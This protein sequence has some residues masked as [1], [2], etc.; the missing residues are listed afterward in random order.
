MDSRESDDSSSHPKQKQEEAQDDLNSL[1]NHMSDE[2]STFYGSAPEKYWCLSSPP[3][4]MVEDCE[5]E[6]FE[7]MQFIDP[8]EL[9]VG[10]QIASGGQ[11]HVFLAVWNRVH[12][13]ALP[14]V[15]KRLKCP[16]P[17]E[18]KS[19][20]WR[21]LRNVVGIGGMCLCGVL[22]VCVKDK[23]VYIV[24]ERM[25]GDLRNFM[26]RTLIPF[27]WNDPSKYLYKLYMI[28]CVASGMEQL[29]SR[30][31]LHRDLKASNVLF[32]SLTEIEE[33]LARRMRPN[34]HNIRDSWTLSDI[35]KLIFHV[36]IK[37]GDYESSEG[38]KGTA[39]WRAPEV[40]Q[41]LKQDVT[42]VILTDK[43]DVY[44]YAMLCYEIL[45]GSIPFEGHRLSDYDLVLSGTRPEL[46]AILSER[47]RR[48][49]ESC[50][51]T[52]PEQ[53][54]NF[55]EITSVLGV[56]FRDSCR[57]RPGMSVLHHIRQRP[58][59]RFVLT[60]DGNLLGLQAKVARF[61][62]EDNVKDDFWRRLKPKDRTGSP[63]SCGSQSSLLAMDSQ[64]LEE[65][66]TPF[67]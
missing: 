14:V 30:G 42:P 9:E 46:P 19:S 49:L 54:P 12:E 1:I 41:Q 34:H 33:D 61:H 37:V 7:A 21:Q 40:L 11:A 48:L 3:T 20:F 17:S 57:E 38:V 27:N 43:A 16:V 67:V 31:L 32:G 51:Q 52:D 2:N 59:A 53:R 13:R 4:D 44:S 56:E 6:A 26:D 58:G 47:L 39:F 36:S 24:M 66:C 35:Y 18:S 15:A 55:E 29:H 50:W 62:F 60:E 8:S 5:S 28:W 22:G 64:V 10:E 65:D 63:G 23:A 45:T 25:L